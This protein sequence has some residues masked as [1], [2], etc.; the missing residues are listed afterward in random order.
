MAAAS[1]GSANA[2]GRILGWDLLRGCCAYAIISYHLMAWQKV[3]D[4]HTIGFYGVYLF[5][6]LS[7]ASLVLNYHEQFRTGFSLPVWLRFLFVRYMRLLP[8]F[9]V[10]VAISL[11]W[12]IKTGGATP[13]LLIKALLNLSFTFGLFDPA[14]SS[15]VVGGWSLGIEF[16]FYLMFPL[17]VWLLGSSAT[18]WRR[19]SVF[20]ALIALQFYWIATTIALDAL[21]LKSLSAYHQVPAFSAYFFGGC[22]I[23]WFYLK[24]RPTTVITGWLCTAGILLGGGLMVGLNN[25]DDPAS[26][27]TGWRGAALTTLCFALVWWAGL[28]NFSPRFSAWP[29]FMG[30]VTYGVYLIH[31][32]LYFGLAFAVAP[33]LGWLDVAAGPSPT[34]LALGTAIVLMTSLLAYISEKYFEQ[35]IRRWSVRRHRAAR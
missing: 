8:L 27:L 30:D 2:P 5:F 29:T 14:L 24:K 35:P 31:P 28:A 22:I 17:F 3:A 13:A 23:G 4:I 6:V 16:V 20:A 33:K 34:A 1:F 15:M 7:G 32:V 11:L 12:K 21:S 19:W 9:A 18:N 26:V 10:L 25:V